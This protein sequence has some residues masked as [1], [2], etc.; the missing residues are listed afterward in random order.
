MTKRELINF[1]RLQMFENYAMQMVEVRRL[2]LGSFVQNKR[3]SLFSHFCPKFLGKTSCKIFALTCIQ[4]LK[5]RSRVTVSHEIVT[6]DS[7][8]KILIVTTE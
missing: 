4:T 5:G 7:Q 2:F 6:I 1:Y 3:F 8:N